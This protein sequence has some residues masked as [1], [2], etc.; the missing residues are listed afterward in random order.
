MKLIPAEKI[1]VIYPGVSIFPFFQGGMQRGLPSSTL[2]LPQKY[3]LFLGTIE[4]RKNIIGLIS[5]YE[6]VF[7][8]LAF[9]SSLVIAGAKG[10]NDKKIIDR[11]K[12]SPLRD[13][14]RII[15]YVNPLDKPSLYKSAEM[16]VFPSFYEGFG[17]PVLE[18]M[19]CGVP[20]IT[21]NR[22]SLPEVVKNSAWLINPNRPSEIGEAIL[23]LTREE[24]LRA[25]FINKGL[26][27]AMKLTWSSAALQFSELLK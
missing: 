15:G 7:S 14:I 18:A 25:D 9:P 23:K 12:K 5:A 2:S 6:S 20:V 4:P 19:V 13:K 22:S 3:I 11:I 16:F 27:Q 26:E 10:W 17:F 1:K 8:E 24:K 21:S